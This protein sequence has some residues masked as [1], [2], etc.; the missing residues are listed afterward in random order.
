M[1]TN[2]NCPVC[3]TPISDLKTMAGGYFIIPD[4]IMHPYQPLGIHNICWKECIKSRGL[5]SMCQQEVDNDCE[6]SSFVQYRGNFY[7]LHTKCKKQVVDKKQFK[8]Q[9]LQSV[10]V[11][12]PKCRHHIIDC[13]CIH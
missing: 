13:K 1:E 7:L 8:G 2:H 9:V 11:W 5:R 12:C 3:D 6:I 10:A 4:D